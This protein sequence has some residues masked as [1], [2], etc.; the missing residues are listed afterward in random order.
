MRARLLSPREGVVWAGCFVLVSALL[1]ATKF[2]S[3]DPDSSLYA[4]ISGRLSQE[5]ASRWIAPEWWGF[6]PEANMTGLF[7]EHPAGVFLLPAALSRIG[8]P[9]E[10]AAYIVGMGA[11][12]A[13]VLLIGVLVARLASPG[14]ARAS[15]VLLQLMPV[16]F[17]F[18]IRAN[19]E[20]PMLVAL[21]VTLV[22]LERARRSWWWTL[23]VAA[24]LTIGL[25]VKGVFVVLVC[26]A[27]GLWMAINPTRS[28]G[29]TARLV[30]VCVI[31]GAITV[32]VAWWYDAAYLRVTGET[33]WG[34]YWRRQLGP[35]T[36]ATPL[37]NASTLAGHLAFYVSR[38]LWFPAPWSLALVAALWRPPGVRA[39]WAALA[40]PARR[41]L[42]FALAFAA[43]AILL[44]S[45][46]SR[47][48]ER[49]AFSAAYMIG[50]A[51][52]VVAYRTW[53]KLTRL[54]DSLDA[55][56]PAL[57]ASLWLALMLL[58]LVLGPWLPR[59]T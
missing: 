55:R 11:G 31:A 8:I 10:Q 9:G 30:A 35:V 29:T 1:V 26:L 54:V 59:L 44:L 19:H 22:S 39:A 4:S 12:L 56:V 3:T 43:L 48:A 38:L 47:F 16:A 25:L 7:R 51:G 37:D 6:W 41:G 53:P 13:A 33:F 46:S 28:A 2:T 14:D 45:P 36:I 34:P 5:P 27:A 24:G 23:G 21:L 17:L 49:Y 42:A 15:L 57:P 32:G 18:R 50:A 52:A 40:D 20:Y 58:R